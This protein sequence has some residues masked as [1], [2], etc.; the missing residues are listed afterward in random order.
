VAGSNK[1]PNWQ[2]VSPEARQKLKGILKW[3]RTGT[4]HPFTECKAALVK[5]GT[6]PE[7]ANRI[8]AVMKDMSRSSTKWRKGGSKKAA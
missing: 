8:C 2:L 7:R 1:V 5:R 3:A 6:S 4:A